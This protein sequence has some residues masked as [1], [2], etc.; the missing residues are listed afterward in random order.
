MIHPTM[1]PGSRLRAIAFVQ[2]QTGKPVKLTDRPIHVPDPVR[3]SI[4]IT[5]PEDLW[6][7]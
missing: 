5:H 3:G 6:G 2:R 1:P 4:T 7:R